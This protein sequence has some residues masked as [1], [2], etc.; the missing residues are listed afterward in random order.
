[1]RNFKKIALTFLV[2]MV[3]MAGTLPVSARQGRGQ[4]MG[5]RQ[6]LA[7]GSGPMVSIFDGTPVT[8]TGVVAELPALG[9]PG[10][11]VDTGSEIITVYG[12]GSSMVWEALGYEPLTVDEEVSIDAY[13]VTF[14]DASIKLVAVAITIDD[15]TITLRDQETGKPVWRGGLMGAGGHHGSMGAGAGQRLHDGSCLQ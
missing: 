12:T 15:Q 5:Q 7:D 2:V 10:L 11:K 9:T 4:A 14:S 1:M 3:V 13:E 8:V 6:G